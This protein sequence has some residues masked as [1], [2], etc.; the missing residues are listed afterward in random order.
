MR[1]TA[2]MLAALCTA[3]LA[4]CGA[5]SS[6]PAAAKPTAARPTAVSAAAKAA[7]KKTAAAIDACY[8]R[9]MASGDIYVRMV[10]PGVA[11]QAQELGGEW[12]W[13]AATGKC[14]TSAQIIIASAP[15]VAGSCTQVGY[16]IDNPGY[17]PNATPALP[18]ASIAAESGPAC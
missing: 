17:D 18:L 15:Q 2:P 6:P 5:A 1:N 14:L 11:T 7:A 12:T 16:K 3:A 4:A 8:K 13:D 9:P 10:T